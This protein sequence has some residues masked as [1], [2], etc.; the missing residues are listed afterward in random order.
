MYK[1]IMKNKFIIIIAGALLFSTVVVALSESSN[2]FID[3]GNKNNY[4]TFYPDSD[5]EGADGTFFIKQSNGHD[6]T[7]TYIENPK[8]YGIKY[9]NSPFGETLY[10]TANGITVPDGYD[11]EEWLK[12]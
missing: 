11:V 2:T 5:L 6:L 4:I 9:T 10:K 1:R 7:G 12:E 3:P 8:S